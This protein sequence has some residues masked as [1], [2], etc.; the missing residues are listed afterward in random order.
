MTY[1]NKFQFVR[2]IFFKNFFIASARR[3]SLSSYVD[4]QNKWIKLA[5]LCIF[6]VIEKE[7]RNQIY[8]QKY[9]IKFNFDILAI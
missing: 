1:F 6:E 5:N 3:L 9:S 8:K 2:K 7:Y 4:K